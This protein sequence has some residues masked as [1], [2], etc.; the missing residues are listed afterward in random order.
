VRSFDANYLGETKWAIYATLLIYH[1]D[2]LTIFVIA[3]PRVITMII[4]MEIFWQFNNSFQKIKLSIW[5]RS[6]YSAEQ[7]N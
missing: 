1:L 6:T 3:L 4:A 2:N 7:N 5:H